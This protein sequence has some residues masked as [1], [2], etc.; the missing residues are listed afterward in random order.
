MA[1][2]HSVPCLLATG[3]ALVAGCALAEGANDLRFRASTALVHDSNLFRLSSLA[4]VQALLGRSSAAETISVIGFGV[5]YDKSYSLQRV[6]FDMG[7]NK[8]NYQNFSYLDFT[9]INY[10]ATWNWAYTPA[11][12]GKLTTSRNQTLNNFSDFQGFNQRNV[13]A[14]T[15][16]RLDATYELD[17]RWRVSAGLGQSAR[18]NS[19]QTTQESDFRQTS[20]DAGVRYVLASG[21]SIGY[22]LRSSGGTYTTNRAIPS[23]GFF[24]NRFSQIDNE[25]LLTWAVNRDSTA[26][27]RVGQRNRS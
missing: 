24:D 26:D 17:A 14:D 6:E 22:Q 15:S 3:L 9:A 16:T 21:S 11:L 18:N 20:V 10:N 2:P 23:P 12:Q 7:L 5:N 25:I 13:R 27:F 4:N 8:Y 1:P 19:I